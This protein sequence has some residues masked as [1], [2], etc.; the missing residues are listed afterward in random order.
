VCESPRLRGRYTL[1]DVAAACDFLR[2]LR[3][4]V[5]LEWRE[6][7]PSLASAR[8]RL[9]VGYGSVNLEPGPANPTLAVRVSRQDLLVA[10]SDCARKDHRLLLEYFG[11]E[12]TLASHKGCT[13]IPFERVDENAPIVARSLSGQAL[14]RA[15]AAF[16]ADM[17][18]L[19]VWG[20]WNGAGTV[21]VVET[22]ADGCV[23]T[24]SIPGASYKE[25]RHLTRTRSARAATTVAWTPPHCE[26]H[27]LE[28]EL[29]W[30]VDVR[31]TGMSIPATCRNCKRRAK[32]GLDLRHI[33]QCGLALD[34]RKLAF[35]FMSPSR[36]HTEIGARAR[37]RAA[38]SEWIHCREERLLP[39]GPAEVC[40]VITWETA[41][42]TNDQRRAAQ[43]G[44]SVA[45]DPAERLLIGQL[46]SALEDWRAERATVGLGPSQFELQVVALHDL[47]YFSPTAFAAL[48]GIVL[49]EPSVSLVLDPELEAVF[50]QSA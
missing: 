1:L 3:D 40:R 17:L 32:V 20:R 29:F 12:L 46:A 47:A 43:L 10:T 16:E 9:V 6:G 36:Y 27:E 21:Q 42:L 34:M 5:R 45:T 49:H 41:T 19:V 13:A 24:V 50:S 8:G 30:T 4:D 15:A 11:G 38:L 26:S 25:L 48:L 28:H 7:T 44:S 2:R 14:R 39:L 33:L 37:A 18:E 23:L 31:G 22:A 35:E